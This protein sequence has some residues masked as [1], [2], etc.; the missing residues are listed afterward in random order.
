[1]FSTFLLDINKTLTNR[2]LYKL[3]RPLQKRVSLGCNVDYNFSVVADSINNNSSICFLYDSVD[4][5]IVVVTG[6]SDCRRL[7]KHKDSNNQVKLRDLLINPSNR[8][9]FFTLGEF[10]ESD[11]NWLRVDMQNAQKDASKYVAVGMGVMICIPL[12]IEAG[13]VAMQQGVYLLL[14]KYGKDFAIGCGEQM[15]IHYIKWRLKKYLKSDTQTDFWDDYI[16]DIFNNKYSYFTEILEGGVNNCIKLSSKNPFGKENIAKEVLTCFTSIN[17]G[18]LFAIEEKDSDKRFKIQIERAISDCAFNVITKPFFKA[19]GL[20]PSEAF[21][22]DQKKIANF[23][24]DF[25]MSLFNGTI[26]D[27]SVD[28]LKNQIENNIKNYNTNSDGKD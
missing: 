21:A 24:T 17:Y 5:I 6:E 23:V 25:V 28:A 13:P 27:M 4:S 22:K 19:V 10:A 26:N 18:D 7:L 15:V 11:Y 2:I 8:I 3:Q 9:K 1:M 14:K 20:L 16:V 12:L